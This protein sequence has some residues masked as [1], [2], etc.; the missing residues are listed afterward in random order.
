MIIS[1]IFEFFLT[2]LHSFSFV[3]GWSQETEELTEVSVVPTEKDICEEISEVSPNTICTEEK[4]RKEDSF[5]RNSL[6][7][8]FYLVLI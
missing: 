2:L 3:L 6:N 1:L 8:H 4:V 5:V 7:L